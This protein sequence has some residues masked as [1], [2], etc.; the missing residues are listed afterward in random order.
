[1]VVPRRRS[2]AHNNAKLPSAGEA[3]TRHV[4]SHLAAHRV[5][6]APLL[7]AAGLPP[8]LLDQPSG[9]I[10]VR[11]QIEFL[12]LAAEAL[13]DDLIGFHSAQTIDFRSV[14]IVYYLM[15][16]SETLAT[17][18]QRL[19]RYGSSADEA[20]RVRSR[21]TENLSVE[22]AYV[23]VKRHLDRHQAEF[24]LAGTLRLCRLF[25]GRDLVPAAVTLVHARP[26]RAAEIERY[27][28]REIAFG[29]DRDLL[30]FEGGAGDLSLTTCD[31]YLQHLLVALCDRASPT[32]SGEPASLRTSVANAITPRLRNG[33]PTIDNIAKDLGMSARTLTRKLA[34]AG[35]SF[36]MVLDELRYE[37]AIQY[38]RDST[39]TISQIA[40]LLG[41]RE[42]SAATRAF[43]RWTGK[44]PT[45]FR[46][47]L[48]LVA[49]NSTSTSDYEAAREG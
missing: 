3:L 47:G 39:S 16:S 48:K 31:P 23:G 34:E 43:K 36:S 33:T 46:R 20:L 5:E 28:G 13:E 21:K 7:A 8:T 44:T 19:E 18:L 27:V 26:A 12:N 30:V 2:T 22:L 38:T 49:T 41:Y 32:R 1:M 6:P 10:G 17:A 37:L 9:G 42:P 15:A 29:A 25:T 4:A 11:G 14:G 45:E 40:W 24:W 35:T